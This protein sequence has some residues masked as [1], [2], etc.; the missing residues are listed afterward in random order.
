[1]KVQA[2]KTKVLNAATGALLDTAIATFI[3]TLTEEQLIRV[4]FAVDGGNYVALLTYT[5]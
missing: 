3:A 1:M 2:L 4:H 5:E